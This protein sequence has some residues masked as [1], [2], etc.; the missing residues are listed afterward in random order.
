MDFKKEQK[1]LNEKLQ[2]L[3][4]DSLKQTI[5]IPYGG[6]SLLKWKRGTRKKTPVVKWTRCVKN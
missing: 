3:E 6:N 4:K 5:F 2:N 1:I